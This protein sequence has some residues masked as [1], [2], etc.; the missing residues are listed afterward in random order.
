MSEECSNYSSAH[1]EPRMRKKRVIQALGAKEKTIKE[2]MNK[3]KM[4]TTMTI[5]S[6][7]AKTITSTIWSEATMVVSSRPPYNI[8][9]TVTLSIVEQITNKWTPTDGNQLARQPAFYFYK[10]GNTCSR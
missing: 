3:K 8:W 10:I 6:T 1:P 5:I 2:T 4:T 7:T 9:L